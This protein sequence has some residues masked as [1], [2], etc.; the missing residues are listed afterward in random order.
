VMR[1]TVKFEPPN[2]MTYAAAN[3]Y[4]AEAIAAQNS[5]ITKNRIFR[6][7]EELCMKIP[8]VEHSILLFYRILA[9]KH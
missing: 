2:R 8:F 1:L 7:T 3:E 9:A 5:S 6:S 4:A